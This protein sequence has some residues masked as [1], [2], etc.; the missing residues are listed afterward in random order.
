MAHSTCSRVGNVCRRTRLTFLLT[1]IALL[2]CDSQDEIRHYSIPKPELVYA[3]NHVD[4][5]ASAAQGGEDATDPTDR[6]L[7]AIVPREAR[8]WYFKMTGPLDLVAQQEG[9]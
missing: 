7:G 1:S 2:G 5:G 9:A 6:L 4:A 8:T 3:D